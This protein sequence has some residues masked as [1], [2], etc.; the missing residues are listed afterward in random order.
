M[1]SLKNGTVLGG[2][3]LI[4]MIARGGMGE[5]YEAYEAKLQRK[6]ALK[7]I[8]P[9]NPDEHDRD[10]LIRRFMQEA[11][12][13]ARVNHPN[14]V[15]IYAIDNDNGT[16]F[17]A[18]EYVE[19]VSFRHLLEDLIF[20]VDGALPL[21]MQMLEGLKSLHDNR[22]IHRDLKPHNV[23]LRPDGQIKILDFG[24]AKHVG[25]Q[26]HTRAGVIVG[27]LPYMSPELKNGAPASMRSDLWSLGSIFFECLVGKRLIECIPDRDIE[28]PADAEI[29]AEFQAI[30]NKMCAYK[31]SDRYMVAEQ[32]IED[33]RQYQQSR[34]PVPASVWNN[35]AKKV[36][37]KSEELRKQQALTAPPSTPKPIQATEMI[38]HGRAENSIDPPTRPM[39]TATRRHRPPPPRKKTSSS[40]NM[41]LAAIG[42]AIL[43]LSALLFK[44]SEAPKPT[45]P[46]AARPEPQQPPSLAPVARPSEPIA[47]KEP[48]DQQMLFLEPTRIPTLAWS[49]ALNPNEY[50]IQIAVDS[51]FKRI[52]IQEPIAG[53]SF[54]P[55]RVLNEGSYFWR[56]RPQRNSLPT[57][58]PNSFTVSLLS[59][60]EVISPE[61]SRVFDPAGKPRATVDFKWVCKPG[62][63]MYMV[64][65]ASDVDFNNI[66]QEKM[67]NDCEWRSVQLAPGKYFWRLR[68]GDVAVAQNMWTSARQL[69]V[70]QPQVAS[71]AR[72]RS[73]TV[74]Q[75]P[76]PTHFTQTVTLVFSA[77]PRDLAS[78]SRSV[79]KLPTL[80]W[81]PVKGA[82]KYQVQI[83]AS[84][85][86][87]HLLSEETT[88]ATRVEWR[89]VVPGKSYWRVN[90]LGSAGEQSGFSPSAQLTV[91]L[92]APKVNGTYKFMV[93]TNT[94][95]NEQVHVDW[96]AIPLA[97]KYMVQTGPA[98]SLAG[99]EE[100]LIKGPRLTVNSTPGKTYMRVAAAS[101]SGELLSAYSKTS[102]IEIAPAF[103]LEPPQPQ[104]PKSG[105][106]APS[107][108]GRISVVFAWSRVNGA[109]NYVFEMATDPAFNNVIERR[110]SK[111]RGALLQQAELKG[112]VY[113]RVRAS[114]AQGTSNW[115]TPSFFDVK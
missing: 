110:D 60:P 36:E 45:P 50:D 63:K 115:S 62:A 27:T 18:M 26:E 67:V 44:E 72:P 92:P 114:G 102:T 7:V 4:R 33:L 49:R 86:F 77:K 25:T 89:G 57:V 71:T 91:L 30:L 64:Q 103:A 23:L 1:Q 41:Y 101:D 111:N 65:I 52:V 48:A 99:A 8:A 84:R 104:S 83:S 16:P 94:L 24:I 56:L 70:R 40:R 31:Q 79:E 112:R 100:R 76:R 88:N 107:K 37:A 54:R 109:D 80:E 34:S 96:P 46:V 5:V 51:A 21:F 28:Y 93:P 39:S 17:I 53:T 69:S 87:N 82:A 2:Y 55:E 15:T 74:L 42:A 13:L 106:S 59:P 85:D 11:R 61:H 68:Q 90:A 108:N 43:L 98:R 78:L 113:W 14:V 95:G 10:D 32:V 12:T 3:T 35:L 19:G 22:I 9:S 97:T 29:P 20:T 75:E 81:K 38:K 73:E 105:A 66:A 6:V 47:L 58:G